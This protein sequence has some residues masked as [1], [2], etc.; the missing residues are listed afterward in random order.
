M[1]S[2]PRTL[3]RFA[4]ALLATAPAACSSAPVPIGAVQIRTRLGVEQ[5]VNTP[6]GIVF[7]GRTAQEGPC[8]VIAFFGD[9]A[10]IEPGVI[11][12]L[13]STL[14]RV[15]LGVKAPC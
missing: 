12:P 5:G 2:S 14:A 8:E 10:S 15:A 1:R 4:A 6:F 13:S 7:L 3:L 9:G 11:Q